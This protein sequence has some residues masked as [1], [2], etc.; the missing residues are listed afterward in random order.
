VDLYDVKGMDLRLFVNLMAK[1]GMKD[2]EALATLIY[3]KQLAGVNQ[4]F[5]PYTTVGMG[6]AEKR[7]EEALASSNEY[8]EYYQIAKL[9]K[10]QFKKHL[11][12]PEWTGPVPHDLSVFDD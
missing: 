2:Y 12:K 5:Y 10:A 9:A 1:A 6:V 11:Q 3:R 8:P 7:G 4:L